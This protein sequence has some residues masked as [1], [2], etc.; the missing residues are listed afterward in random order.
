MGFLKLL[1]IQDGFQIFLCSFRR[2]ISSRKLVLTTGGGQTCSNNGCAMVVWWLWAIHCTVTCHS[3]IESEVKHRR[4]YSRKLLL[5]QVHAEI[6]LLSVQES[7]AKSLKG[8]NVSA[9]KGK[10]NDNVRWNLRTGLIFICCQKNLIHLYYVLYFSVGLRSKGKR[11]FWLKNCSHLI[12]SL[13]H[14]PRFLSFFNPQKWSQIS[15]KLHLS[16]AGMELP[17]LMLYSSRPLTY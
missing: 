9:L 16:F 8:A 5:I 15:L 12:L 6:I 11:G 14:Y 17:Q 10:Q 7:F 1:Q 4:R 2:C 13:S 3:A